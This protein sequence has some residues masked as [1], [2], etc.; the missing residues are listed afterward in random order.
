MAET[1]RLAQGDGINP[2]VALAARVLCVAIWWCARR[3]LRP[4]VATGGAQGG[5]VLPEGRKRKLVVQK[6]GTGFVQYG[7]SADGAIVRPRLL[8]QQGGSSDQTSV[9]KQGQT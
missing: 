4:M 2:L 6:W 1:G 7:Q 9:G 5:A 3:A 8:A